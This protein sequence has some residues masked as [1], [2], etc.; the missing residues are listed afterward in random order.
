MLEEKIERVVL[1]EELFPSIEF[2]SLK[3]DDAIAKVKREVLVLEDEEKTI[4]R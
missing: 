2:N 4:L 1:G 3:L